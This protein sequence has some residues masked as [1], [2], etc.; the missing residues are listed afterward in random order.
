MLKKAF[1]F[2]ILPLLVSGCATTFTN[3]TPAQQERNADNIYPVEVALA[4]NQQTLRWGTIHAQI[5]VDHNL[6]PLHLTGLMTNRWE[7]VLPV[8]PDRKFIQYRFRFDYEYNAIGGPRAGV[9]NSKEYS[10]KIKD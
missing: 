10:L 8:A 2:K 1:S 9:L 5:L 7:G 4:S 6:V 3:L